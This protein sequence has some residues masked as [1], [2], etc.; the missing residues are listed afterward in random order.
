VLPVALHVHL[1]R[2]DITRHVILRTMT[3]GNRTSTRLTTMSP[4]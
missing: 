3:T 2:I 4:A 1:P